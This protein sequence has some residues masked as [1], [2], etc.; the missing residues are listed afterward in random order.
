MR[1][2]STDNYPLRKAKAGLSKLFILILLAE[3]VQL[4]AACENM[5]DTYK[6]FQITRIY[7][8]KINNLS[9]ITGYKSVTLN[10]SNP[11]G[12]IAK[13]IYIVYGEENITIDEMVETVTINNLEIKGYNISVYTIDAHGNKSVPVTVYVFPN[14]ED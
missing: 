8:P 1:T 4:F 12:D 13:K 11:E 6:E 9:A 10:W 7:S 3:I 2:F 5:E 14:G